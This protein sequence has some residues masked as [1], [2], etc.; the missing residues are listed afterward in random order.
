MVEPFGHLLTYHPVE[1]HPLMP[2]PLYALQIEI[3]PKSQEAEY[4]AKFAHILSPPKG[5]SMEP[6][7]VAPELGTTSKKKKSAVRAHEGDAI[8]LF[9][10]NI[11]IWRKLIF[12]KW[13][14]RGLMRIVTRSEL[15]ISNELRKRYFAKLNPT[16]VRNARLQAARD[17][18]NKTKQDNASKIPIRGGYRQAVAETRSRSLSPVGIAVAGGGM[19]VS[20]NGSLVLVKNGQPQQQQG[21]TPAGG[22]RS[23]S[24]IVNGEPYPRRR[25]R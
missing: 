2:V 16:A 23:S 13:V 1:Q 9:Y 6:K 8:L 14:A 18:A 25:L 5:F 22:S 3:F 12:R 24:P 17:L 21:Q 15:Q 7:T 20:Q 11:Q 4:R 10:R 19:L